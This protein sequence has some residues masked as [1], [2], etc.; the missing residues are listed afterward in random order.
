MTSSKVA[1]GSSRKYLRCPVA[2]NRP[3]LNRQRDGHQIFHTQPAH[4]IVMQTLGKLIN[5]FD[6][7]LLR[8]DHDTEGP[9]PR[10][11]GDDVPNLL[12]DFF[13]VD[14]AS[15]GSQRIESSAE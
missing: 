9:C 12:R 3:A 2:N 15:G 7:A 13:H 6:I 14:T 10:S 11:H 8:I 1:E 4:H 5:L